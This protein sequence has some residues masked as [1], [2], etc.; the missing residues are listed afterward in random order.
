[1]SVAERDGIWTRGG[2]NV[3]ELPDP[4]PP[5]LRGTPTS[6]RHVNGRMH[7]P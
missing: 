4:F 2:V 5:M 3:E 7:D 6:E 1:M